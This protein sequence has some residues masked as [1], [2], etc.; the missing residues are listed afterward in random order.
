MTQTAPFPDV[1]VDLV[2]RCSYRPQWNVWLEDEVRDTGPHG[3][4]LSRGLTLS[5]LVLGINT[6]DHDAVIRVRHLF[7][8]PPA[9]YDRASWQRW[10]FERFLDVERHEAMEFFQIGDQRPYVPNHGPG[11]DVYVVREHG[12]DLDA[13]TRFT[14][15]IVDVVTESFVV[16][17][18]GVQVIT[19]LAD[20]R[21]VTSFVAGC[22]LGAALNEQAPE[23][24]P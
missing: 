22:E 16:S 5:I 4:V 10:L 18:E 9:T 2:D 8:V 19:R 21:Y 15:E 3:E 13:A 24:S 17:P 6:Y 11:H 14:G 12:D 1:L 7:P 23:W 20:G